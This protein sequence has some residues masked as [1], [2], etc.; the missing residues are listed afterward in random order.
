MSQM[1]TLYLGQ[2]GHLLVMSELLF[3]GWNV[4][5]PQ[6]DRG[7]DIFVVKDANGDL[8]RVQVKTATGNKL[9]KGHSAKYSLRI[10]QLQ[11]PFTPDVHYVF[12]MRIADGWNKFIVIDRSTLFDHRI[13]NKIGYEKNGVLQLQ[14]RIHDD[15]SKCSKVD[16]TAYLND[17][18]K[19]P[20]I[21]H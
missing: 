4:A 19:F 11:T 3:R 13:N 16:F 14:I 18:S 15:K 1:Q 17:W 6:V 7:D 20:I 9:V 8:K 2:A 10:D 21:K 5:I 12:V